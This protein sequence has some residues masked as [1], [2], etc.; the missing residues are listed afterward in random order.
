MQ[1]GGK[2]PKNV[3]V[4]EDLAFSCSV[5]LCTCYH[6]S[7]ENKIISFLINLLNSPTSL[8]KSLKRGIETSS[9]ILQSVSLIAARIL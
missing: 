4:R 5:R 1:K 9:F 6:V 2:F 8:L 3:P 7:T